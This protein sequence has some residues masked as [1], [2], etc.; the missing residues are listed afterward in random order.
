MPDHEPEDTDET[1]YCFSFEGDDYD[2]EE[3]ADD[4]QEDEG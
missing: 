3:E 1:P 2:G 4:D